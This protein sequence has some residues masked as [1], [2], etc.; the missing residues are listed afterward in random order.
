MRSYVIFGA[1]GDAGAGAR[2]SALVDG[3][4]VR[5]DLLPAR[6]PAFDPDLPEHA[7]AVLLRVLGFSCNYRDRAFCVAMARVP[8]RRHT[9]IGS[10][11]VAEVVATGREVTTLRPGDRVVPDHHYEGAP[12][13]DDGG[14]RGVVTNRA[15]RAALVLDARRLARIP[16]TMALDAAAAFSLNAQ[17]AYAMVRRL[18]PRPGARVLV[19]SGASNTSLF[20][21]AAL[22]RRGAVPCVATSSAGAAARLA[23][24]GADRVAVTERGQGARGGAAL[25]ALA[26]EVG[27]FD[28]VIDPFY[29]LHLERAVEVLRPF[30]TYVTCGLAGQ[31]PH[32]ARAAGVDVA[33]P[34]LERVMAAVI[35]RNLA[36]VGNCIGLS[37]DLAAALADHAAGA[38]P[39]VLDSTFAG[40]ASAGAF[41]ARSFAAPDRFGKVVFRLDDE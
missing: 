6:P 2:A 17:T 21:L 12:T 18:A 3:V 39:C 25:G 11:F 15:S 8:A 7:H 35:T 10:E 30:G 23:A 14:A 22:R 9:A 5:C 27:G 40:A 33:P 38:L 34:S 1:A 24:L 41:L 29:D 32:A 31:N 13:G 26:E 37:S 4:R 16:H 28:G 36:I 19:T 20:V